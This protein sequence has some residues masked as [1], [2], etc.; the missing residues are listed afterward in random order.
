MIHFAEYL[1]Q[2]TVLRKIILHI[3]MNY[4]QAL[5]A[6]QS[7]GRL[8]FFSFHLFADKIKTLWHLAQMSQY[9]SRKKRKKL[10]S[11]G[12]LH[13]IDASDLADYFMSLHK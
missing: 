10:N 1:H 2:S 4:G 5:K 8:Y 3:H 7:F 13:E 9:R 12:C 11:R 6:A